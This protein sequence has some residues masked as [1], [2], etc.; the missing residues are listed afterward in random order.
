VTA[1]STPRTAAHRAVGELVGPGTAASIAAGCLAAH[2]G[3][4][5]AG[6]VI[7]VACVVIPPPVA[8]IG[9][10]V[11]IEPMVAGPSALVGAKAAVEAGGRSV[12]KGDGRVEL[13]LL[14]LELELV[15]RRQ[16]SIQS[17]L[18]GLSC[19]SSI[20]SSSSS[21]PSAISSSSEL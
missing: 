15:E 7:C 20:S 17:W 4:L 2:G 12:R 21:S 16:A 8:V 19:S 1:S 14:L 18:G 10:V 9:V 3:T 11:S 6:W 5:S 13:E